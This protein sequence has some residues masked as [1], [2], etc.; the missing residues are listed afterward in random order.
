MS[1]ERKMYKRPR[2]IN[3]GVEG[4]RPVRCTARVRLPAELW[5]QIVLKLRL[6]EYFSILRKVG[7]ADLMI[8]LKLLMQTYPVDVMTGLLKAND[9]YVLHMKRLLGSRY[10]A[11]S[12]RMLHFLVPGYVAPDA[13]KYVLRNMVVD[14]S[15]EMRSTMQHWMDLCVSSDYFDI[16]TEVV[17]AFPGIRNIYVHMKNIALMDVSVAYRTIKTMRQYEWYE[18]QGMMIKDHSLYT[19]CILNGAT[20]ELFVRV[21]NTHSEMTS[22]YRIEGL[23]RNESLLNYVFET[24]GLVFDLYWGRY[25]CKYGDRSLLNMCLRLM[26]SCPNLISAKK[27]ISRI[28]T[29]GLL[30]VRYR[31]YTPRALFQLMVDNV[32]DLPV[33]KWV[34]YVVCMCDCTYLHTYSNRMVAQRMLIS[35]SRKGDDLRETVDVLLSCPMMK[36]ALESCQ[37]HRWIRECLYGGECIEIIKLCIALYGPEFT[38]LDDVIEEHCMLLVHLNAVST[39]RSLCRRGILSC[40]SFSLSEYVFIADRYPDVLGVLKECNINV[41]VDQMVQ[42]MVSDVTLP[43]EMSVRKV[44]ARRYTPRRLYF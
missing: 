40:D 9:S 17:R 38:F 22:S 25:G 5:M 27:M 31:Q 21:H 16:A 39:I 2:I 43:D 4:D 28:Q 34:V 19:A 23:Y 30:D 37:Y 1:K 10:Q 20:E 29:D 33:L 13:A 32:C 12:Y 42:Q 44:F 3:G 15:L 8:A 11:P 6:S 36:T 14:E 18:D 7:D 41:S 35:L 24:G 26:K